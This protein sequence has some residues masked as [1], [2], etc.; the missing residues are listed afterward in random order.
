MFAMLLR[1]PAAD[2]AGLA[3]EAVRG[4]GC[5]TY[6]DGETPAKARAAAL[7]LA[8]EDAVRSHHSY[9]ESSTTVKNFQ[10]ESDVIHSATAGL[11]RNGQTIDEE[12]NGRTACGS[13][14]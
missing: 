11:L 7:A 8:Q 9:V 5:Y 3:L 13:Q 1:S 10:L 14:L 12:P 6:G 2:A 4:R